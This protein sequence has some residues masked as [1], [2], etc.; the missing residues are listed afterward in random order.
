[1]RSADCFRQLE[2]LREANRGTELQAWCTPPGAITRYVP[3]GT[4]GS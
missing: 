4:P 3:G 1:M 2:I